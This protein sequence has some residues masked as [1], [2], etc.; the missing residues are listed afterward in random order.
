MKIDFKK[1][2]EM[3]KEVWYKNQRQFCIACWIPYWNYSF[4]LYK[5]RKPSE[6]EAKLERMVRA[7]NKKIQEEIERRKDLIELWD[8]EEK[9][10]IIYK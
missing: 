9:D 5:W 8:L 10:F 2:D 7:L 1:I 4:Y 3:R 6:P